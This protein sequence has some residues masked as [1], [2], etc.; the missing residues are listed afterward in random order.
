MTNL[1]GPASASEMAE[2]RRFRLLRSPGSIR[3]Y[4]SLVRGIAKYRCHNLGSKFVRRLD[5]KLSNRAIERGQEKRFSFW[6]MRR[7]SAD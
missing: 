2:A 7:E 4:R 5:Y 1:V 6:N 3:N